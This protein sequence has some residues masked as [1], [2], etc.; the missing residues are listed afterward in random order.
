MKKVFKFLSDL[1]LCIVWIFIVPIVMVSLVVICDI[2][3]ALSAIAN[4][5]DVMKTIIHNDKDLLKYLS[6]LY[7][8]HFED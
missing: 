7:E 6:D 5:E 8:K 2:G 3:I 1:L 4:G